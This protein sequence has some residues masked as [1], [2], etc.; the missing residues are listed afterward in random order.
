MS[1][2]CRPAKHA[3]WGHAGDG[4]RRAIIRLITDDHLPFDHHVKVDSGFPLLE[5]DMI[6]RKLASF[7]QWADQVDLIGAQPME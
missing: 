2:G 6:C 5:N 4:E 3:A 7:Y 1:Q